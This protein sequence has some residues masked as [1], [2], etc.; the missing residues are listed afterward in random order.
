[1]KV[2][3]S[4]LFIPPLYQVKEGDKR[5][6]IYQIALLFFQFSLTPFNF[7]LSNSIREGE[8]LEKRRFSY[9]PS[10]FQ[11]RRDGD[12]FKPRRGKIQ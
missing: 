8:G 11:K 5:K 9:R 7:P 3:N 1:L 6:R 2:S 10:L 4:P 12:E